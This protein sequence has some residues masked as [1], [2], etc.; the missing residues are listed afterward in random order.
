MDTKGEITSE[1]YAMFESASA[2]SADSDKDDDDENVS[3]ARDFDNILLHG[4]I[5]S[6]I[7]KHYKDARLRMLVNRVN[8]EQMRK[9]VEACP[10]KFEPFY[11]KLILPIVELSNLGYN[12]FASGST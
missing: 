4:D 1:D 11:S 2:T 9:M 3:G 6:V 10:T 5:E 12:L 7:G 8:G